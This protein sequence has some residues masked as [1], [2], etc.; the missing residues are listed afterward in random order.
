[1]T[2]RIW[3]TNPQFQRKMFKNTMSVKRSVVAKRSKTMT[4]RTVTKETMKVLEATIAEDVAAEVVEEVTK[5]MPTKMVVTR[6]TVDLDK[7]TTITKIRRKDH[8]LKKVVRTVSPVIDL[9]EI[10]IETTT[11]KMLVRV[12]SNNPTEEDAVEEVTT[13][14]PTLMGTDPSVLT[15]KVEGVV[16]EAVVVEAKEVELVSLR[17]KKRKNEDHGQMKWLKTS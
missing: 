11:I 2:R 12:I 10:T 6:T 3:D 5:P 16:L 7:A 9:Q 17:L 1:L 14:E 13:V 8:K 15:S 4:A